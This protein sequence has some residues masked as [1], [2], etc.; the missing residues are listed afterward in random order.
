MKKVLLALFSA[1]LLV[2]TF[3]QKD[4]RDYFGE[5]KYTQLPLSPL[6]ENYKSYS[7]TA[8][9]QWDDPYR[10]DLMFDAIHLEG[11]EKVRSGAHQFVVK[12]EEYPFRVN[13]Y[14]KETK[15]VKEKKDGIEK[16]VNYYYYTFST[17]YRVR[18]EVLGDNGSTL[19]SDAYDLGQEFKTKEYQNSNQAYEDYDKLKKSARENALKGAMERINME[20][21]SR[22]GF[23]RMSEKLFAYNVKPKKYTYEEFDRAFADAQSALQVSNANENNIEGV[24]E[25]LQPAIDVWTEALKNSDLEDKKAKINK[26]VTCVCYYNLGTAYLLLHEYDKAVENFR[27]MND[28][29]KMFAVTD[30]LESLAMDLKRREAANK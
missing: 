7:V 25:K 23:P 1:M 2:P 29:K 11:F 13:D 6:P 27:K 15:V 21:N 17:Q 26:N 22:Y 3:A 24:K 19:M 4:K 14:K 16:S 30:R 18:V 8:E 20:L 9:T 28:V 12:I 5:Y 10:R